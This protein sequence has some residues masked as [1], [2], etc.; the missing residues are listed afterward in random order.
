MVE[1]L[2]SIPAGTACR[3]WTTRD[4]NH[5]HYHGQVRSSESP[6]CFRLL[7][8][9]SS[10]DPVYDVGYF[11]LDLPKLL[12]RGF[13][14]DER[15]DQ[16]RGDLRVRFVSE[17]RLIYLQTRRDEPRLFLGKCEVGTAA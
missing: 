15:S 10:C 7:W 2:A 14:R 16:A 13:I 17:D 4:D 5:H 1:Q 9:A 8:R 12:A 3:T 6:L 11:R